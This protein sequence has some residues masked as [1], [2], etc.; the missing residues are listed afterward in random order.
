MQKTPTLYF[1]MLTAAMLLCTTGRASGATLTWQNNSTIAD[2]TII[3]MLDA[4]GKWIEVARVAKNIATFKDD[5]PEG[6]YRVRAYVSDPAGDLV[7]GPSNTGA[8]IKG[9]STL[10]VQP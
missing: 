5:K 3:E 7:S 8:L 1:F 10:V 2:G 6:I 9:S 4:T